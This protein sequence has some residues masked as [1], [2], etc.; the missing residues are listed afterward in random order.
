MFPHARHLIELRDSCLNNGLWFA[1]YP[2]TAGCICA[3]LN[4]GAMCTCRAC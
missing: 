4:A 2:S 1:P 3:Q